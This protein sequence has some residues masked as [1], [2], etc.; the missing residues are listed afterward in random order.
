[1]STFILHINININ[2]NLFFNTLITDEVINASIWFNKENNNIKMSNIHMAIIRITI[3]IFISKVCFYVLLIICKMLWCMISTTQM[4]FTI[5][6]IIYV[7]FIL[8]ANIFTFF[9]SLFHI[10]VPLLVT[11]CVFE[12]SFITMSIV[13]ITIMK[14]YIKCCCIHFWEWSR[15][16]WTGVMIFYRKLIVLFVVRSTIQRN[17]INS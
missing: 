6:M 13:N 3:T 8:F 2:V 9:F 17:E 11:K 10:I 7:F 16:N 4:A 14:I 1:M 15:T 12:I 5:V